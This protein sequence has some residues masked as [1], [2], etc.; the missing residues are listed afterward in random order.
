MFY[1]TSLQLQALCCMASSENGILSSDILKVL[2]DPE[3]KEF[4][5]A[6]YW[7]QAKRH[8]KPYIR[9][10]GFPEEYVTFYHEAIWKVTIHTATSLEIS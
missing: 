6:L 8:L 7:A 9:V 4:A 5:P 2:G 1:F 3:K 10:T